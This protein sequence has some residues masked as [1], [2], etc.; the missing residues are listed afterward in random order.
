[1]A[2]CVLDRHR[3]RRQAPWRGIKDLEL[4]TLECVDSCNNR[5]LHSATG[6]V[7]LAEYEAMCGGVIK[8]TEAGLN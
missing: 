8:V 6:H 5:R 1:M 7:P 4:A 2:L 3:H